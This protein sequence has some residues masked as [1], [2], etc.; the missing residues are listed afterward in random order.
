MLILG[1]HFMSAIYDVAL[2]QK[3]VTLAWDQVVFVE[4]L[5]PQRMTLL[6]RLHCASS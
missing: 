6:W 2:L 5:L 3:S 1:Q 4:R